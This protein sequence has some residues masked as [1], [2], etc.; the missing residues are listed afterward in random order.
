M[1]WNEMHVIQIGIV[2]TNFLIWNL[3]DVY[4]LHDLILKGALFHAFKIYI[5]N[6]IL[7]M[8]KLVLF[9]DF[10]L[11]LLSSLKNVTIDHLKMNVYNN[12]QVWI[13]QNKEILSNSQSIG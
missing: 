4:V 5:K 6:N 7:M 10:D 2:L 3:A 11:M 13:R 8:F 12:N 1:K 9:D